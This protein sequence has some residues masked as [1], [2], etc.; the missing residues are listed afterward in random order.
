MSVWCEK[1]S[2]GWVHKQER[3]TFGD[4]RLVCMYIFV[5]KR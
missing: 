2:G 3:G 4:S 5:V 1:L